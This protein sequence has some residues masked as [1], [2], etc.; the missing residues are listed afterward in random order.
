M[1]DIANEALTIAEEI[2]PTAPIVEAAEAVA[3]TVSDPTPAKIMADIELVTNLATQ[4]KEAM[5]N[6]HPSLLTFLKLLSL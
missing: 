5:S 4:L 2:A 6:A 3:T 1:T